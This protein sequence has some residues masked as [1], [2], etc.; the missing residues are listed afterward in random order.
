MMGTRPAQQVTSPAP[1]VLKPKM[2]MTCKAPVSGVR[3]FH[4]KPEPSKAKGHER[5]SGHSADATARDAAAVCLRQW[6]NKAA[7]E[8]IAGPMDP[9]ACPAASAHPALR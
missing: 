1:A 6:V 5:W 7:L 2:R 4:R 8:Q 9:P 3:S